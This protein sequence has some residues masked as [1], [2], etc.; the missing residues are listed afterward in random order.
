MRRT[1][2][3]FSASVL[4][5]LFLLA[6]GNA[7]PIVGLAAPRS[8]L[9]RRPEIHGIHPTDMDCAVDPGVDFY[10]F[11][12]GGWLHRT[13]IPP[14][15]G[16]YGVS[17]E[18]HDRTQRQLMELLGRLAADSALEDG[19]DEWKAL[20]LFQ[21]GTDLENRNARG[22][23][24]I[25][26]ILAEIDAIDDLAGVHRFLQGSA[27]VGAPG[28]FSVS[29]RPDPTDAAV[30][31][32]HLGGPWLGLPNRNYY[33]ENDQATVTARL[34]YLHASAELLTYSGYD[35]VTAREA[36]L[37]V[38]DLERRLAASTLPLEES[39]ILARRDNPRTLE[40]LARQYPLMDWS[41]YLTTLGIVEQQRLIVREDRYLTDL[42]DIIAET[43]LGVLKDYLRLQVLWSASDTLSEEI[44]EAAFTY[45][46]T[47]LAGLE[48]MPPLEQ[49]AID[50]VNRLMGDALGKHYVAQHFSPEAKAQ[51]TVLV[52]EVRDAF[53]QRIVGNPWLTPATKT[54]A[55][56]KLAR[57]GVKVGYPD[58]WQSYASVEIADSY[59]ESVRN[60]SNAR[61]RHNL[62]QIGKPVDRT[63]WMVPPQ[64]V[65]AFY[66]AERNEI[67][68]PAGIL[69]P[70]FFD[71]QADAAANFGGIGVVVGHEITHGFDPGGAQVDAEGNLNDWWTSA[72]YLKFKALAS[73]LQRQ[74]G[75]IELR[76]G[77][78]VDGWMT[79]SENI[80]DLGGIQVAYDALQRRL[81]TTG[82]PLP[83]PPF[84]SS[85]DAMGCLLPYEQEQRFFVTAASIWRT[86]TRDEF[87]MTAVKTDFHAPAS[88]R[89][90]QP[91]RNM[92]AFF[93]AFDIGPGD[94]MWLSPSERIVIW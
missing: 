54:K 67:L 72:D 8:D 59:A 18:I 31:V 83:P 43:P 90:T 78:F 46:G 2:N 6:L 85:A 24:P 26:P 19:T 87:L 58:N 41:T 45:W 21:Q 36:T 25:R 28:L 56:D 66:S 32:A 35:R 50:E 49:R 42:P 79:A 40:A 64:I 73:R 81:S 9:V 69:Q 89:A 38:H 52:E 53:R 20:R 93:A 76:A 10:R 84:T 77:L 94:P 74:Y 5:L 57:M 15:E 92:D 30:V 48:A 60:A 86:K 65:N 34:A 62:D 88:V 39:G 23:E 14:D 44:E 37:A 80:A 12:N 17:D 91:L 47:A 82:G 29:G 55:M 27:F 75:A 63:E 16:A 7:L 70:P 4:L 71:G 11:A 68:F 13:T 61:L 1:M 3:P 22:I 51:A 33:L